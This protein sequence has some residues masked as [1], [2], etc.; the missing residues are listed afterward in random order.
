MVVPESEPKNSSFLPVGFCV[1]FPGWIWENVEGSVLGLG[2]PNY[3]LPRGF[4]MVPAPGRW[5]QTDSYS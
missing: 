4:A 3:Y 1:P 5:L 2:V